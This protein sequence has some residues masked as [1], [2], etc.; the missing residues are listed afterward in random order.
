MYLFFEIFLFSFLF[1]VKRYV[2][3]GKGA[4][5]DDAQ[6]NVHLKMEI[7]VICTSKNYKKLDVKRAQLLDFHLDFTK[8]AF[9]FIL[10]HKKK[11]L[12]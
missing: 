4:S 2:F 11:E 7:L 12:T 1:D 9:F 10:S 6:K 3:K 8:H 5:V